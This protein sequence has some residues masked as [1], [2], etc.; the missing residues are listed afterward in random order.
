M[1]WTYNL[2]MRKWVSINRAPPTFVDLVIDL[3]KEA[4]VITKK[5]MLGQG[6]R[7][8]GAVTVLSSLVLLLRDVK[9]G[10]QPHYQRDTVISFGAGG[11]GY[12]ECYFI[13]S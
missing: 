2:R 3:V 12:D 6:R 11:G 8:F 1:L 9:C 10:Y 4:S 5:A 7:I 13:P